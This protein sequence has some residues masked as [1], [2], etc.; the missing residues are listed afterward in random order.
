[1]HLREEKQKKKV[2]VKT[3]RGSKECNLHFWIGHRQW[4]PRSTGS[5][6]YNFT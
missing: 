3:L 5:L 1:M 6:Q 4:L 2:I